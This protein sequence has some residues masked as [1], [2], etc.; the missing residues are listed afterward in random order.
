MNRPRAFALLAAASILFADAIAAAADPTSADRAV[1]EGLFQESKRL[2]NANDYA[3]ACP[4]LAE[5]Q[6]LV[7][8][9]GTLL[10][11][12]TC[13][14][15]IGLTASAWAEFT[16]AATLAE[17]TGQAE[18]VRYAKSHAA[19][20]EKSLAR[21]TLEV[22]ETPPGLAIELDGRAL[23]PGAWS[24][25]IPV[26]PGEHR[27][28]ASAPDRVAWSSTVRVSPGA[29]AN[30]VRVPVL[31]RAAA[32]ST[33]PRAEAK[34]PPPSDSAPA[35]GGTATAT[36]VG[37]GAIAAGAIGI[38][39]GTIFGL[40]TFSAKNDSAPHC[41][42]MFCDATGVK[43]RADGHTDATISTIAFIG[44][45]TLAA[46]GVV[47]VITKPGARGP[48]AALNASAGPG[49]ADVSLRARW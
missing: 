27:V 48:D 17:A 32:T 25:P 36:Y 18:R 49:R 28:T 6:R 45:A 38:G 16:Q 8:K 39:V 5:S 33:G 19:A 7:P 41:N 24:S 3:A 10:N 29:T 13:H 22:A 9:L 34:G 21:V 2:M 47:L 4:K 1:A 35:K 23:G 46:A 40:K 12:A 37:I 15:K 31:E 26:D 14:E 44:G 20:L 30:V 42:G 11:L 43:I